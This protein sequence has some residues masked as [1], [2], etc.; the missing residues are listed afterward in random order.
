MEDNQIIEWLK[1]ARSQGLSDKEI[2][3]QLRS[4]GWADDQ[5][6]D[7][8]YSPVSK[9]RTNPPLSGQP[10]NNPA[11]TQREYYPQNYTPGSHIFSRAWA[12][13]RQYWKTMIVAIIPLIIATLLI[14]FL[15]GSLASNVFFFIVCYLIFWCIILYAQ[16][17]MTVII[18]REEQSINTA[19]SISFRLFL[20]FILTTTLSSLIII[21][22]YMLFVIPGILMM[23]AFT[24]LPYIIVREEKWGWAAI[25]RS[26]CLA[27]NFR[28]MIFGD[29][30]ILWVFTFLIFI[31]IFLVSALLVFA[32]R[33]LGAVGSVTG[34]LTFILMIT[35]TVSLTAF[36]PVFSLAYFK[37]IYQDLAAIRPNTDNDPLNKRGKLLGIL[38]LVLGIIIILFEISVMARG[39]GTIS[40]SSGR[41]RDAVRKTDLQSIRISLVSYSD[42][43]NNAYPASLS[44][45]VPNYISVLPVDPKSGE[46]YLYLPS[47]AS[48]QLPLN[49]FLICAP[50][51]SITT[52]DNVYCLNPEGETS[53]ISLFNLL[54]ETSK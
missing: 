53:Q 47:S 6:A 33:A 2:Q 4:H 36:F 42:N 5:I 41:V 40:N 26:Y 46:T 27:K 51:E 39:V 35:G 10:S 38:Y 21:G 7:L 44:R 25:T 45:L 52:I 28:G 23:L 48:A 1:L 15:S 29:Y 24:T 32:S 54:N 19:F 43:N 16:L 8:L 18:G 34:F 37:I 14:L 22:G 11:E 12:I 20:K 31:G 49:D 50:L 13:V 17:V 3:A 9:F 30:L